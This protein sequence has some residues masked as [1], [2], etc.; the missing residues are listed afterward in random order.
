MSQ[1]FDAKN[2]NFMAPQIQESNGHMIMTNVH[3]PQKKKYINIDTRH[4]DEFL[5]GTYCERSAEH[6]YTLPQTI[7]NVESIKVTNIEISNIL[8][9]SRQRKNTYMSINNVVIY[10]KDGNYNSIEELIRNIT[11]KDD[12][13]PTTID[14]LEEEQTATFSNNFLL[15]NVKIHF[16]NNRISFSNTSSEFNVT[17]KFNIDELG[18]DDPKHI[19]SKLGWSMGFRVPTIVIPPMSNNENADPKYTA[20]APVNFH[21]C[22]YMFLS[23]DE[24]SNTSPISFLAPSFAS[25]FDAN[26]LARVSVEDSNSDIIANTVGGKLLS[27]TRTYIGKTDIRKLKIQLLDE[28]GNKVDTQKT[29]F[30][31]CME[32]CYK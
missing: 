10:L 12:V 24:Y 32:I 11:L 22:K 6:I 4:E 17:I 23:V 16:D 20:E 3:Q 26:I 7:T 30:S 18:G 14:I 9:F 2:M 31:F 25:V 28:F 1:Y 29:D 8:S 13:S 27:D 15:N 21:N 19:K 5:D